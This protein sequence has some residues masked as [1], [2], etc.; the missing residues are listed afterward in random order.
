M[1]FLNCNTSVLNIQG[2]LKRAEIQKH[3]K[4]MNYKY[5]NKC[6]NL[7]TAAMHFRDSSI[8]R[9]VISIWTIV[10]LKAF[11]K[12]ENHLRDPFHQ[13]SDNVGSMHKDHLDDQI[14]Q[15]KQIFSLNFNYQKEANTKIGKLHLSPPFPSLIS[16][17]LAPYSLPG[18]AFP[19][20]KCIM[21]TSWP[22][23]LLLVHLPGKSLQP[24]I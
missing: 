19:I 18:I 6:V 11:H 20:E 21:S 9:V 17:G 1:I 5:L 10:N 13:G 23:Q 15:L 14:C 22:R 4:H 24:P 12:A 7:E 16:K 8:S 2:K 3:C